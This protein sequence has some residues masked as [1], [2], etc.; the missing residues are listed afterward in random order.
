MRKGK[1]AT[2]HGH[3]GVGGRFLLFPVMVSSLTGWNSQLKC[4]GSAV[5]CDGHQGLDGTR[6]IRNVL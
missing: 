1:D 2:R 4:L 6:K 5:Q 3:V